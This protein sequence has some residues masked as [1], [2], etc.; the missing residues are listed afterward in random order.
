MNVFNNHRRKRVTNL[1]LLRSTMLLLKIFHKTNLV[2]IDILEAVNTTYALI[3]NLITQKNT[4]ID[5]RKNLCRPFRVPFLLSIFFSSFFPHLQIFYFFLFSGPI[6]IKKEHQ[7]KLTKWQ[8]SKPVY[9]NQIKSS[10]C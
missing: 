8:H 3:L 5:V 6:Q 4:D 10:H 2:I 1:Q 9:S 7:L